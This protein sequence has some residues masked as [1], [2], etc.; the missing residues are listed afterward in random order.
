MKKTYG[1]A[2]AILALCGSLAWAQT[3]TT[4][5][6]P[7]PPAVV[8]PDVQGAVTPSEPI[9]LKM[10][11][12]PQM[13]KAYKMTMDMNG[14]ATM[15]DS[16]QTMPIVM[17]M[18]AITKMIVDKQNPDGTFAVRYKVGNMAM[19]MNGSPMPLPQE[20]SQGYEFRA[21]V[22]KDG[23]VSNVSGLEKV[24]SMGG[25]GVDPTQMI[26]Q[27]MQSGV[28]YPTSPVA[29]GEAWTAVVPMPMDN[30]GKTKV[31][32]TSTLLGLDTVN[33]AKVARIQ[34]VMDGP[35]NIEIAQPMAMKMTGNMKGTTNYRVDQTSGTLVDSAGTMKMNMAMSM[36]NPAGNGEKMNIGIDMNMVVKMNPV[37]PNTPMN[38]APAKPAAKPVK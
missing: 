3:D 6:T 16:E 29:V 28:M 21:N 34:T 4:P 9:T 20:L 25:F 35:M 36:D 27:M 10:V 17:S 19:S 30:T 33:G 22:D 11:L 32:A 8:Q 26:N 15:G 24:A 7:V 37:A 5:A 14:N 23:K 18:S 31:T 12:K 1:I 38:T 2:P 13:I